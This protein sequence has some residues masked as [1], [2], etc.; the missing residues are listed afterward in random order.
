MECRC[1]GRCCC[2]AWSPHGHWLFGLLAAVA[3]QSATSLRSDQLSAAWRAPQGLCTHRADGVTCRENGGEAAGCCPLHGGVLASPWASCGPCQTGCLSRGG[4]VYVLCGGRETCEVCMCRGC[5]HWG[6][7][8][9]SWLCG[10][11]V[12]ASL[13]VGVCRNLPCVR[14]TQPLHAACHECTQTQLLF[15]IWV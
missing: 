12:R 8:K 3:Q 2:T 4:C 7:P 1:G 11:C 9:S 5:L 14:D 13:H 15:C 6:A 10:D